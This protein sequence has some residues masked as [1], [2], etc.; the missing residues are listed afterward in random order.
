MNIAEK[1]QPLGRA[2]MLPI[3]VLPVAAILL[4]LGQ[5][6]IWDA[7][8]AGA[9]VHNLLPFI[10]AAGNAIFNNLGLLFGIGVAVGLARENHGAAGMAG[11]VCF[12]VITEGA[13]ALIGVP[14]SALAGMAPNAQSL[15]SD[16]YKV[17]AIAKVSV[18]VGIISG[19][20]AGWLYNRYSDIKLPDYLAFFGGRRFVPIASGAVGVLIAAALGFGYQSISNGMDALSAAVVGAGDWG[21]FIYGVLNRLLIVTG[22]HHIINNLAWFIVG[23][24]HG[25]T[26]DLHRFFAGDPN[27][28]KFM[29][30]FFPVMMFGLPAACLAMYHTALPARRKEVGGLLLSMAL[31]AFLTGVTEPI[32]FSF[33]FLAPALYAIHALLTGTAMALMDILGIRLGFG[34]SAGLFDYLINFGKATRPLWLLPVGAVYFALYY[35]LFRFAI[36]MF[37]LKTPGREDE[38]DVV[39]DALAAETSRGHAFVEALGGSD[40]LVSVDACTTRLRLML[41]DGNAIDERALKALGARGLVRPS[42]NALQV[43]LGPI[44]DQVAGE[45]RTARP[46]APRTVV[47]SSPSHAAPIAKARKAVTPTVTD[48]HALLLALGGAS[49]VLKVETCSSR[50]RVSVAK[51]ESIDGT[52]LRALGVRGIVAPK[53]GSI[54]LVIGPSADA[55]AL[56][57]DGER[58]KAQA[59]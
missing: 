16:A 38:S 9:A 39:S 37:N 32:E 41:A 33:M 58:K 43:V 6:D 13:K 11:V 7:V 5:P 57:L 52:R 18:P 40:N 34:F 17:A 35:G 19:L 42:A 26:G 15:A 27:A 14:V 23:D 49:N 8:H 12:L 45:I 48:T 4:R 50:L 3:A 47:K 36:R 28:G 59:G 25:T 51:G 29:S 22:L 2:L 24:Y 56:Q 53:P 21:L 31:T 44:A 1:L 54:H 46:T 20:V 10:A 55:V 30:G